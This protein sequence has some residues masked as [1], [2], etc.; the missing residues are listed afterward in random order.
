MNEGNPAA[1]VGGTA[2]VKMPSV[3]PLVGTDGCTGLRAPPAEPPPDSHSDHQDVEM[4][5]S[6]LSPGVGRPSREW[7]KSRRHPRRRGRD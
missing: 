2:P 7:A 6:P 3:S 1:P 4:I 5:G